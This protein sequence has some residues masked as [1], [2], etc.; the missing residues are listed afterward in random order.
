VLVSYVKQSQKK[1]DFAFFHFDFAYLFLFR[2]WQEGA[3]QAARQR[4][5]F[6]SIQF[7]KNIHTGYKNIL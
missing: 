2:V 6:D 3:T 5:N 4:K 7:I 1:S